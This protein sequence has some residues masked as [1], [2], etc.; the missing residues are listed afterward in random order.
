MV[1]T[2]TGS[3]YIIFTRET[4]LSSEKTK[5]TWLLENV[6]WNVTQNGVI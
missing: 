5:S 4:K 6:M 3:R 2:V 1:Q